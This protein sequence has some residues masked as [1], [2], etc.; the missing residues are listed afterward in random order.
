MTNTVDP[1]SLG[2]DADRLARLDTHLRKYVDDGRLPGWQ[3]QVSRSGQIVHHSV[4]GWRDLERELPWENDTIVRLFS[5]TKPVTSVAAMM[6][7]EEGLLQ[8]KDPVSK[9]IPEFGDSRVYRQ[10]SFVKPMTEPL[11]E[12]MKVWHLFTHT[13]G[14]TYG[15]HNTHA[16]DAIY[17]DAGFLFAHPPGLSLIHI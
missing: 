12:E 16:V 15:F 7:E 11:I 4:Y 9:Y 2:F 10:G 13:S 3:L 1:S 14:L 5:M 8:L 6:L 17:R